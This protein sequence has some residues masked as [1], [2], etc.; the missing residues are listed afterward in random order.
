MAKN[1]IERLATAI[2]YPER[3]P[4]EAV[5]FVFR[6]DDRPIRARMSGAR[7]ILQWDFPEGASVEAL[8]A[9]AAGRILRE[10]AVIA[11]DPATERLILWQSAAKGAD[12]RTLAWAFQSFLNSCDWWAERV[13][14]LSAPKAKLADLIINP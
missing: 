6:V 11:W 8:A 4:E 3:V 13:G 9:Y 10:E 7:M 5:S 12:E 14:E 2:G 1:A